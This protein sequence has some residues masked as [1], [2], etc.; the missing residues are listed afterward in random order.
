M[1][2][3]LVLMFGLL[4]AP[5]VVS[6][7]VEVGLDAGLLFNKIDD[8]DDSQIAF[9]IPTVGARVGFPAGETMIVETLVSFDWFK[10]GDASSTDLTLAPGLNFLVG[11]QAYVRGEA[12]LMYSSFDTGTTD[13]S[14]TQYL[15]GAAVGLRRPLGMGGSLL[16]LEAGVD[17][18][19][20]VEDE[21]LIDEP[22]SWLIRAVVGVSGVI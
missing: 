20:E 2:R 3:A 5:A 7:Q 14:T 21:G 4:L 12:G 9:S 18:L 13:G 22:A 16:R 8:V 15:F 19:L 10:Q 6:A 11:E 17:R 1:R